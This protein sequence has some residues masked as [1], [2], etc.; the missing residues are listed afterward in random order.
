MNNFEIKSI[1]FYLKELG[2]T[3]SN[4]IESSFREDCFDC[5]FEFK[6]S[7]KNY[8]DF[9]QLEIMN[10]NREKVDI[11]S[12]IDQITRSI[13]N[14][15]PSLTKC[16]FNTNTKENLGSEAIVTILCQIDYRH[17][18]LE[19]KFN[20]KLEENM[21]RRKILFLNSQGFNN[22]YILDKILLD[23]DLD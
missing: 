22:Q 7:G 14:L 5:Y 3:S 6:H 15:K 19:K 8:V 2:V 18:F 13:N 11:N 9:I 4:I 21:L 16:F 1:S 23:L 20:L 17:H 12:H 10:S